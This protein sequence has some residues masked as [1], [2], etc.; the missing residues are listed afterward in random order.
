MRNVARLRDVTGFRGEK[1]VELCLTDYAAFARPLFRPGFL[2]DKWPAI[3]FYVELNDV[4]GR[5][6]Y[7]LVQTKATSATLRPH[8]TSLRISSTRRDVR[9]LLQ[10][11]GPTHVLG[12][13]EPSRR[14]FAKSV[15]KGI[16]PG[17]ITR[18]QLRNELTA[19]NLRLLYDEVRDYW[20]STQH[21]PSA[22]VFS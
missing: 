9:R 10:I 6:P 13:H 14:V 1:I 2:G 5:R 4:R 17:A 16:D 3:D 22:S 11:P 21:K 8:D 12:V 19:S 15:H 18:I 20:Q 7:F